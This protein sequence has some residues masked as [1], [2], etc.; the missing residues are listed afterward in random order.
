MTSAAVSE[1]VLRPL[2]PI[3][4][5]GLAKVKTCPAVE[6]VSLIGTPT[7]LPDLANKMKQSNKTR[8]ASYI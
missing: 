4:A 8:M 1:L 6:C 5:R 7:G 2:F 3:I